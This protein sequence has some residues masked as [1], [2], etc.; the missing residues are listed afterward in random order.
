MV[1]S[2]EPQPYLRGLRIAKGGTS[3]VLIGI[4]LA[5]VGIGLFRDEV[6]VRD[7]R[8]VNSLAKFCGAVN[9]AGDFEVFFG[10]AFEA[11]G[12]VFITHVACGIVAIF[13]EPVELAIE[14]A[15]RVN[16]RRKFFRVGSDLIADVW[17]KEKLGQLRGSELE[18][19][20]GELC[21]VGGTEVSDEIV[22]GKMSFKSM[23]LLKPCPP[24]P[25]GPRALVASRPCTTKGSKPSEP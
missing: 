3:R 13:L 8:L 7:V 20:F 9:V 1:N 4:V 18:A 5:R 14:T 23:V 15:E 17:S 24:L 12:I 10:F 22:L 19:D 25:Q 11:F 2:S 6:A 16:G 21:G